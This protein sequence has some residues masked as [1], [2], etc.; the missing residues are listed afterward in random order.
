MST[1]VCPCNSDKLFK[2]CCERLLLRK[3]PAKTPAQLM[4]SRY[5]AYA[6]GGHGE[7]LLE[8]SLPSAATGLDSVCLF[9]LSTGCD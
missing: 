3:M 8:T 7:Y 9:S 5:S 4:R 6:L 1:N 2:S